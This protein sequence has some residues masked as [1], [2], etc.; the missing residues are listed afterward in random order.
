MASYHIS[1][2]IF[3]EMIVHKQSNETKKKERESLKLCE[4]NIAL[5]LNLNLE[6]KLVF[7][8]IEY[9]HQIRFEKGNARIRVGFRNK[10]SLV[11]VTTLF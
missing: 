1:S 8:S 4:R 3:L 10:I 11:I 7:N 9:R 6:T 2:S 5:L